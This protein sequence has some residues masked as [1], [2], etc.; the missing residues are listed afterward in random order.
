M[1]TDMRSIFLTMFPESITQDK[2]KGEE[3]EEKGK[4]KKSNAIRGKAVQ[5]T[6]E[7]PR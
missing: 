6:E 3:E 4:S 5:S 1:Y 2:V 7:L